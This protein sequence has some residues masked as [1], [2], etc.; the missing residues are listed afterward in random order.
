M[1]K[2]LT[3]FSKEEMHDIIRDMVINYL[4]K[5]SVMESLFIIKEEN[6][7]GATR[8]PS[9]I[10]K[11]A[12]SKIDLSPA[13]EQIENNILTCLKENHKGMVENIMMNMMI[14][15][16]AHDTRFKN[17]IESVF[18]EIMSRNRQGI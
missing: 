16:I 1:K 6:V 14:D 9:Q 5:D 2:E 3:A 12:I 8:K 7:Y 15:G 17:N 13:F 11:D 4:S 18:N 10:I